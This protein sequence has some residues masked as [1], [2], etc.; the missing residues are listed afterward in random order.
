MKLIC[1]WCKKVMKEDQSNDGIISHGICN[2]CLKKL[3]ESEFVKEEEN[4]NN[5]KS[6]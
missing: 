2:E 5:D 6:K 4:N 3:I 1:A